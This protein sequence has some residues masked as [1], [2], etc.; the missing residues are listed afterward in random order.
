MPA[1]ARKFD[2]IE[3]ESL[4]AQIGKVGTGL[5]AGLAVGVAFGAAAALVVGTGGLGAVV[6]GAVVATGMQFGAN[7]LAHAAGVPRRSA[8]WTGTPSRRRGRHRCRSI[9]KSKADRCGLG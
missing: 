4:L 8:T 5:L 1:A 9:R 2:P 6:L 7:K 3:H